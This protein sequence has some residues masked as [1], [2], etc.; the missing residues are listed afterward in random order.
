MT[1][2]TLF[3]LPGNLR[4]GVEGG[5]LVNAPTHYVSFGLFVL[6]SAVAAS[7]LRRVLFAPLSKL[8]GPFWTR[9]SSLPIL[10][11]NLNYTRTLWIHQLHQE[12]GPIVRLSPTEVSVNDAGLVS[13]IYSYEKSSFYDIFQFYGERNSFSTLDR[14]THSWERKNFAADYSKAN[15]TRPDVVDLV[16]KRSQKLFAFIQSQESNEVDIY[17][18]LYWEAMDVITAFVYGDEYG[19]DLL[20]DRKGE[21]DLEEAYYARRPL[22]ALFSHAPGLSR[23][24]SWIGAHRVWHPWQASSAASTYIEGM[25]LQ[26]VAKVP[27]DAQC[28]YNRLAQIEGLSRNYVRGEVLDHIAAGSSYFPSI[29]VED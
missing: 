29:Q 16:R 9:I 19:S 28:L 11:R 8:P 21:R 20:G 3:W 24:L 14:E 22:F 23:I 17:R 12:Y 13:Q 26:W 7:V 10:Y 18:L 1:F 25:N 15:V 27:M 2:Q 4:P 6:F 5:S